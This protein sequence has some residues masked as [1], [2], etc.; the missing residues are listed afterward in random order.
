VFGGY[1]PRYGP[2]VRGASIIPPRILA[3]TF[4]IIQKMIPL[5]RDWIGI[6]G[7]RHRVNWAVRK[8]YVARPAIRIAAIAAIALLGLII[9]NLVYQ[10]LRKPTEMFALISSE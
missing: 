3:P 7:W 9:I 10:V 4:E 8:F 6:R 5:R 1:L 2:G